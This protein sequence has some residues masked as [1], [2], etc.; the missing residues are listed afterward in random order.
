M[1]RALKKFKIEGNVSSNSNSTS[2]SRKGGYSMIH[3]G[4]YMTSC[5]HDNENDDDTVEMPIASPDA[6]NN[7]VT[8]AAAELETSSVK[9]ASTTALVSEPPSSQVTSV[10][11]I[12]EVTRAKH[13]AK[14]QEVVSGEI[15]CG[16]AIVSDLTHK[17]KRVLLKIPRGSE[18]SSG[19]TIHST[20]SGEDHIRVT[21]SISKNEANGILFLIV[22]RKMKLS[23]IKRLISFFHSNISFS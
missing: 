4:H 9:S 6:T 23:T 1:N 15:N 18:R 17:H 3:S 22:I 11:D 13:E 10:D 20:S 21:E 12:S 14:T 8:V 5:L 16:P 7:E 19:E 2:N